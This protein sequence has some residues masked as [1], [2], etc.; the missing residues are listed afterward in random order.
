[1]RCLV[2]GHSGTTG[3]GLDSSE[4]TWPC[5]FLELMNGA[6]EVVWSVSTVPLHPVGE[7][8]IDYVLRKIDEVEPDLVI[9]SLNAYPCA[10]PVVSASVRHRFGKRAERLYARV[11]RRIERHSAKPGSSAATHEGARKWARR[12]L[13]TRTMAS[14]AEVA[15]VYAEILRRLAHLEEVQ[16]TV[17]AEALFGDSVRARVP[18]LERRVTELQARVRP[19][20]EEHR[21]LWCDATDWL[22]GPAAGSY[23]HADGVH[24][25]ARGNARYA[26]MLAN[27]LDSEL[28]HVT[29]PEN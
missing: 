24:L 28:R 7:R 16:V 4:Q 11:E 17:L 25:S 15:F 12:A 1:M 8:A 5:L 2:L 10:V 19:V 20:A 13:G 29:R 27:S 9:L 22:V 18:G 26:E 21:F 3:F 14:V 6:G 23:W